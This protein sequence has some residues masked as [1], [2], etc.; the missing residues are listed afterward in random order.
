MSDDWPRYRDVD[1]SERAD[2]MRLDKFL[3]LRFPRKSRSF[4]ARAL[5][6]REITDPV[7]TVL[8]ASHTVRQGDVVWIW[9]PG[10]APTEAPPP[11]PEVLFNEDGVLILNKPAGLLAHPAGE[12][13]AWSVVGVAR[14]AWREN[15]V[16]LVHR[17]DR[18]TS[19]TLVLTRDQR[20]NGS[21]KKLF[22]EQ[23][24]SKEYVAIARGDIPWE[25]KHV[26]APIGRDG[27]EIRIKMGVQPDGLPS[28]TEFHVMEKR[29]DTPVGP[30]T[31]VR[32]V[33]HSGRTHQIRVHLAH[34]GYPLLGDRLY[35]VPPHIFL[36]TLDGKLTADHIALTG[37]P[38][39]ALHAARIQFETPAGK[40]IDVQAPL[41]SDMRRWWDQTS[42][43]P[44]DLPHSPSS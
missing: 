28:H 36:A 15:D 7:G 13:Y 19:G 21:L 40:R 3:S 42:V 38:R 9:T 14:N 5:K 8:R 44:H 11:L 39:Q 30:L 37:A 33:L 29:L 16:D 26:R 41:P 31:M 6:R 35:G 24:V 2:G 22:L 12:E 17:L 27:G 23:R 4:F 18:D 34:C 10:I 32:C 20:L 1:V 43:L 25:S